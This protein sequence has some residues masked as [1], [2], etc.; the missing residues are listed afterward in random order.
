MHKKLLLFLSLCAMNSSLFPAAAAAKPAAVPQDGS[1]STLSLRD[2][3]RANKDTLCPEDLREAR[4]IWHLLHY[5]LKV[6]ALL[7]II[8]NYLPQPS[9]PNLT[10]GIISP[11]EL[12]YPLCKETFK[13]VLSAHDYYETADMQ[14]DFPCSWQ[15]DNK[16]HELIT[17]RLSACMHKNNSCTTGIP[18]GTLVVVLNK[19]TGKIVRYVQ[20]VYSESTQTTYH[21]FGFEE[22]SP[23]ITGNEI[24]K[25][26]TIMTPGCPRVVYTQL[27]SHKLND[28]QSL[29]VTILPS[30]K[31][32][33]RTT[34][35]Q[36][37]VVVYPTH[38]NARTCAALKAAL[39]NARS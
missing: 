4:I 15:Y 2:L 29:D 13:Y 12:G 34:P 7:P 28:D 31:S 23:S 25:P 21:E 6:K 17:L 37:Q 26:L 18:N 16:S 20:T 33:F 11:A 39:P 1:L 14:P 9:M 24:E 35:T 36:V 19:S 10:L 22:T 5:L 38:C 30:K 8:H 3:E 27:L 32:F